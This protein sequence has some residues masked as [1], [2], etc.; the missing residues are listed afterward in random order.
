MKNIVGPRIR[1]ARYKA[2]RRVTQEELAARMQSQGIDIDR[3]AISKIE[4]GKRPVTD[5]EVV[6][7][8]QALSIKIAI[9]FG[10]E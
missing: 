5:F 9:L 3:S 2:G 6:A 4:T 1:E 10:E 8:C 7:I